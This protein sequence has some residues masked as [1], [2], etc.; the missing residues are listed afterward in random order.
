VQVDGKP[1]VVLSWGIYTDAIIRHLGGDPAV[2]TA[3]GLG[4]GLE[5]MAALH[6]GYDDIRKLS[7]A[8]V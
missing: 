5:R 8:R 3:F 7:A 4:F 6:F 2:H 1:L